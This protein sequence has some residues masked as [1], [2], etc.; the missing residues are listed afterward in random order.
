M[1]SKLKRNTQKVWS[2][3]WLIKLIS[4][5]LAAL[6]WYFVG[7][8]DLVDKNVMVSV[9]VI[10]MPKDLIISNKYKKEVEVTVRGPRSLILEMGQ[11]QNARQIDLTDAA[12][13]TKVE[14]IDNESIPVSRGIEVLRVQPSSIILSLDKLVKK[15][16][17]INAVTIGNVSRDFVLEDLRLDPNVITIT[18][19]QTVLGQVDVLKTTPINIQGI[20]ESTQLQI[21]LV[22]DS[23]LV[24]LIGETSVT[25]D[26]TMDYDKLERTIKDVPVSVV[27]D[28]FVQ[29]V[30]PRVATVTLKIPKM[31]ITKKIDYRKLFNLTADASTNFSKLK[32]QV[33]PAP[34]L[35]VPLEVVKIEPEYVAL[36]LPEPPMVEEETEEIVSEEPQEEEQLN[37]E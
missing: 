5:F 9:E 31:I 33:A 16:F 35:Q 29:N 18:G 12:P 15:N 32:I 4:L 3:E 11:R 19:P 2:K 37:K 28:G 14:M 17:P 23:S 25:A 20:T 1:I 36:V 30:K 8:E 6:L 24:D 27:V 13:G 10:N 21:P 26:I 34:E 22:L 7:G